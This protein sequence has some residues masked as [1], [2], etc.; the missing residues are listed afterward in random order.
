M[1]GRSEII[2]CCY[3]SPLAVKFTSVPDDSDNDTDEEYDKLLS[4]TV[5]KQPQSVWF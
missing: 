1:K 3:M 2:Y 4:K 5:W